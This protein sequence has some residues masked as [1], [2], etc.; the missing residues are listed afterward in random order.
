MRSLRILLWFLGMT[1]W[2]ISWID[3]VAQSGWVDT[4][5]KKMAMEVETVGRIVHEDDDRLCIASSWG[6]D[7]LGDVTHIPVPNVIRRRTLK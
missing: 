7:M 3:A 4:V 1:L 6:A 5:D 2:Q